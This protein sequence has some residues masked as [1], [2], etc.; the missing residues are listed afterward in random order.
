LPELPLAPW[1]A[2]QMAAFFSPAAASGAA[3][4]VLDVSG[5]ANNIQHDKNETFMINPNMKI[6]AASLRAAGIGVSE[7]DCGTIFSCS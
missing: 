1:Q 7:S 4:T 3:A 2:T 6:P 5:N